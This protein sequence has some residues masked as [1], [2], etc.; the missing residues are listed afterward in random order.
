MPSSGVKIVPLGNEWGRSPQRSSPNARG[1]DSVAKRCS[2]P[3]PAR[4]RRSHRSS[5]RLSI[6][7]T[8]ESSGHR[9]ATGRY[10]R[11]LRTALVEPHAGNL[12][13]RGAELLLT[14]TGPVGARRGSG[15]G[16]NPGSLPGFYAAIRNVPAAGARGVM[17]RVP[18]PTPPDQGKRPGQR[19]FRASCG[20]PD[21]ALVI[22]LSSLLCGALPRGRSGSPPQREIALV[23][24]GDRRD[25]GSRSACR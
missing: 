9:S 6:G 5:G 4:P 7:W 22:G 2:P 21:R 19:S 1:H 23:G 25:R 14:I 11:D 17:V 20:G 8:L 3:L 10:Q 13:P 16:S 24:R 18:P 15:S 12:L